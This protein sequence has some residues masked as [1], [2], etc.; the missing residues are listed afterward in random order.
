MNLNCRRLKNARVN[1]WQQLEDDFRQRTED[2]ESD[3]GALRNIAIY[4]LPDG[5]EK[6]PAFFT[7]IRAFCGVIGEELLAESLDV[8]L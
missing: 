6:L 3:Q 5:D 8:W 4:L 1:V 2:G 7:T